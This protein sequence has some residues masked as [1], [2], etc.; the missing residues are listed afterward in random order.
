MKLNC[1]QEKYSYIFVSFLR[2]NSHMRLNHLKCTNYIFFFWKI[3]RL[4]KSPS[5]FNF[6][7]S[8]VPVIVQQ[9]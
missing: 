3:T 8:G 1:S 2:Y 7:T 9:I 4:V 5:K 6:K